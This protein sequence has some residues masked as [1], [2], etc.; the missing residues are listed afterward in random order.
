MATEVIMPQMGESIAEGTITKWLKKVGET[1][2]RDEPIFEISTDKVDAEIPSPVAGTLVEIKV[3]EGQ[4]V[5]I[6]TV[7]AL[8]GEAGEQPAAAPA[9]GAEKPPASAAAA[10]PPAAAPAAPAPPSGGPAP[11]V[12]EGAAK[13]T[14]TRSPE[15]EA[16]EATPSPAAVAAQRGPTESAPQRGPTES[17]EQRG[18]AESA[19]PPEPER[20][21]PPPAQTP[22]AAP[23]EE[24]AVGRVESI[25]ERIRQRSSPLVRK[26]AQDQ[27]VNI[28]E[29]E[30]TGI[31]N[32]VTKNDI[33]SYI[34]NRKTGPA[35]PATA[36]AA[37]VQPAEAQ[38]AQPGRAEP[39][40][41]AAP[42]RP[43]APVSD[44]DE[45]VPM[46]KI[47]KITADN[48]ILS[49]RTSAHVTTVF[50]VDYTN[51]ARLREQHKEAFLQKNG[52]KLTYLPFIFRAAI[53]ALK[54]FPQINASIDGDNIVYHKDIHLGM[55]VALDWGLIVPVIKNAD[56]KSILGLARATQD[57]AERARTKR[58]KPEE[59]QGGTFTVT[60]PGVFGSL[61]GTPIIPQPQVAILGVGTIEKRAVVV[62]DDAGNDALGIRTTGYLALSF[63]HRLVDGADADKFMASVKETLEEGEFDIG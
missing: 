57:L 16:P 28:R 29:I 61:F 14:Q 2:K 30:G 59:I 43:A 34:E 19:P 25:E 48:M 54:K 35:A 10:A 38:P 5:P 20:R 9:Q 60:N 17:A 22:A 8:V 47:R 55:A 46:S 32:R 6:N 53:Q 39:A 36:A 41:P 21:P 1:V 18:A 13:E 33:L 7:V 4:T 56:E 37:A 31:Y 49:K 58:L 51:I 24:R 12:S 27:G 44:R 62:K 52:V 23:Q 45:I 11:P 26:I 3:P 42:S 63:D 15:P 40:P 50:Q